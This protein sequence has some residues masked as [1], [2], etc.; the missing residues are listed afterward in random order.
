M[1]NIDLEELETDFSVAVVRDT[2]EGKIPKGKSYQQ[3]AISRLVKSLMPWHTEGNIDYEAFKEF[4]KIKCPYC[5]KDMDWYG[6]TGRMYTCTCCASVSFP[7]RMFLVS[8]PN[9]AFADSPRK[10]K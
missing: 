4:V 10:G 5:G 3:I 2:F 6:A 7:E 9:K 1:E 8:P